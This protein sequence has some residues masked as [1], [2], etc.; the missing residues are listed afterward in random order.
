MTARARMRSISIAVDLGVQF[1]A[2]HFS[3]VSKLWAGAKNKIA[4]G[5]TPLHQAFSTKAPFEVVSALL[6]AHPD[7]EAASTSRGCLRF[8]LLCYLLSYFTRLGSCK[9][10]GL[11][12]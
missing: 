12:R 1:V 4:D 9:T 7:G 5:R 11:F 8:L 10:Q 3:P 2:L 6:A